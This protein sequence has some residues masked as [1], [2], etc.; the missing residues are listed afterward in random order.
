MKQVFA[1]LTVIGLSTAA[2]SATATGCKV[3]NIKGN[4]FLLCE[5]KPGGPQVP[6]QPDFGIPGAPDFSI[7]GFP[8]KPGEPEK[9]SY[10]PTVP[11][12]PDFGINPPKP[13][14]EKPSYGP[15]VPGEPSNEAPV[16]PIRPQNPCIA[17]PSWWL[18]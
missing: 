1:F 12:A 8:S 15:T 4:S 9:P 3:V 2:M 10:G 7:P 6:G 5:I 18:K 11:G 14:P 16:R 13:Q 17:F